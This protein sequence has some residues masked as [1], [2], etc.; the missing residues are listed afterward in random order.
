[1]NPCRQPAAELCFIYYTGH[2][3][4]AGALLHCAIC[5]DA[6]FLIETDGMASVVDAGQAIALQHTA[7]Q[8][9]ICYGRDGDGFYGAQM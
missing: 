4:R 8:E 3:K 1:M 6:A 5:C 9:S 7:W 2:A